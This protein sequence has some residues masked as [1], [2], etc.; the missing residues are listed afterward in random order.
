MTWIPPPWDPIWSSLRSALSPDTAAI[1]AV[2]FYG[3]PV[4]FHR[5]RGMLEPTG[6]LIIEDAAQGIGGTLDQRPLGGL[7]D[8]A[9]L[10]FGRGKG[11]TSGGG[12]ALYA[13]TAPGQAALSRAGPELEHASG[14]LRTLASSSAQWLLA[15]P[16]TYAIPAA[17]PFLKLGETVFRPPRACPGG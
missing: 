12:G 1:V 16:S 3:V 15:R 7:G 2:H 14:A 9:V 5:L 8:L 10:S 6:I 11:L 13:N 4:D 17:L